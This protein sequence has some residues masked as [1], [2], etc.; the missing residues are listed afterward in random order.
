VSKEVVDSNF[1][2]EGPMKAKAEASS[3]CKAWCINA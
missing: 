3:T 2:S 1:Q